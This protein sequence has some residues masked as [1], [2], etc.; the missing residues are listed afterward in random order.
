ME[1]AVVVVLLV[2]M[3]VLGSALRKRL[4]WSRKTYTPLYTPPTRMYPQR[5]ATL[6]NYGPLYG[7]MQRQPL[8]RQF[9]TSLI[10]PANPNSPL[11]R[12]SPANP[13][14]PLNPN[15]PA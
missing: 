12:N 7:G 8:N 6:P 13:N 10:N 2:V 11:N 4:R 9:A 14:S 5:R 15:H 3:F 1:L